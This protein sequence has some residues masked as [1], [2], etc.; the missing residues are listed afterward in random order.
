M[1]E[2]LIEENQWQIL[3]VDNDYEILTDE[4]YTIRKKSNGFIP[5]T[6]INSDGYVD[7]K[8]NRV[9]YR[10]HR[11]LAIQFIPNPDNLP[12]IDHINRNKSDNRLE[13]LRWV[14]RS[15]NQKNKTS[16]HGVQY[17]YVDEL[18]DDAIEITDYGDYKFEF[19]YYD[20][21]DFWFYNG[22]QYRK[23]HMIDNGWSYHVKVTD[24][25]DKITKI[26]VNKFK[27]LYDLI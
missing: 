2:Q 20:N 10:L 21:N 16:N 9:P 17:E 14:T 7:I 19:Y 23:L 27:K 3:T 26:A 25:N 4:P 18:S 5:I 24:I 13:N 6:R 12:E 1:T 22:V 8:L 11:V 15:Q